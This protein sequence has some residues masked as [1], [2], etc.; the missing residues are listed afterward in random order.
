M[1]HCPRPA[2]LILALLICFVLLTT[3]TFASSED[4]AVSEAPSAELE[5][6]EESSS[7]APS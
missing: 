5:P 7:P 4:I 3:A 1:K 6:V 2:A